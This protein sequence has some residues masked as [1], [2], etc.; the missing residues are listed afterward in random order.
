MNVFRRLLILAAI[1]A[2]IGW[3]GIALGI[4]ASLYDAAVH[5]H[6]PD[7]CEINGA[8]MSCEELDKIDMCEGKCLRDFRFRNHSQN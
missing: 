3:T 8:G 2:T 1:A 6:P 7:A 5:Q 4:G